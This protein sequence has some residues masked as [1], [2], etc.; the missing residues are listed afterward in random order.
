M[1]KLNRKRNIRQISFLLPFLGVI[2]ILS[3]GCGSIIGKSINSEVNQD[4]DVDK[5]MRYFINA[6]NDDLCYKPVAQVLLDQ[7]IIPY[8]GKVK[9]SKLEIYMSNR[10]GFCLPPRWNSDSFLCLR[11][12][13]PRE[14]I[15]IFKD[16]ETSKVL[17]KVEY[18]R[19]L[20]AINAGYK[21]CSLMIKEELEKDIAKLQKS[22]LPTPLQPD[23]GALP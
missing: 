12:T 16:A 11:Y 9:T 15:V 23:T 22:H 10:D 3:S 6:K 17:L 7:G 20:F 19:A 1:K 2:L 5:Y 14:A 21:E 13:Y 8:S 18:K 4:F